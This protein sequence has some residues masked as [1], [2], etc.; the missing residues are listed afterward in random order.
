VLVTGAGLLPKGHIIYRPLVSVRTLNNGALVAAN[1]KRLTEAD[2][3]RAHCCHGPV[4]VTGLPEIQSQLGVDQC[5]SDGRLP[6][7][8]AAIVCGT[9][10]RDTPRSISICALAGGG[11]PELRAWDPL[12]CIDSATLRAGTRRNAAAL[13][14]PAS[15]GNALCSVQLAEAT[16]LAGTR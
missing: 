7:K 3:Q 14:S 8:S 15:G 16:E 1:T 12:S 9:F 2:C 6:G 11:R 4:Q 10:R 5:R 13:A